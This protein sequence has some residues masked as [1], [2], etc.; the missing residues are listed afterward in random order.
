MS[1]VG[2]G[3]TMEGYSNVVTEMAFTV[4]DDILLLFLRVKGMCLEERLGCC[5]ELL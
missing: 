3:G 2:F 4:A 1:S 5:L